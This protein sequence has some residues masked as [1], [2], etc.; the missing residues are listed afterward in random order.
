[1]NPVLD[2]IFRDLAHGT[3]ASALPAAPVV[4]HAPHR[5]TILR[6]QLGAVLHRG[7]RRVGPH[8]THRA[9]AATCGTA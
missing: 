1:M 8:A 5:G 7:A 4:P 3:A 9:Q 2:S 6:A